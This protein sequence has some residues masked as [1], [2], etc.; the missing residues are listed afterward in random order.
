M[1][2]PKK[3]LIVFVAFYEIETIK[4]S[5]ECLEHLNSDIFIVENKSP[6]S[7]DIERYFSDKN[8]LGY[9][10]FNENVANNCIPLFNANYKD[11]LNQYEYITYTD[12]D[13]YIYDAENTFEE[14]FNA[15]LKPDCMIS[16]TEAWL[17]NYHLDENKHLKS[18][19][20]RKNVTDFIEEMRFNSREFGSK[21][22]P[23]N[24]TTCHFF[25]TIRSKDLEHIFKME[26]YSDGAIF[27]VVMN[28]GRKWYK[29]NR[30]IAY[31]LQWDSYYD[32]N[33]Y[34]EWKK[35]VINTI[36]K[37][38]KYSDFKVIK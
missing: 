28:L 15:F 30:N 16:S 29:T 25:V 1:T 4:K 12:G 24:L 31:H 7:D 11:L 37:I 26:R 9:I 34:Y 36:W 22:S 19:D 35:T 21:E 27:S 18:I 38:N 8:I 10:Q 13:L 32:G 14:L 17:G 33:E 5:F 6:Y 20:S 3:H 2:Y 23:N